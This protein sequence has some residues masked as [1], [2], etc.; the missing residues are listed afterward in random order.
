MYNKLPQCNTCYFKWKSF[1]NHD[2]NRF[3]VL[4]LHCICLSINP[5]WIQSVTVVSVGRFNVGISRR[6]DTWADKQSFPSGV[7]SHVGAQHYGTQSSTNAAGNLLLYWAELS[8]FGWIPFLPGGLYLL[9]MWLLAKGFPYLLDFHHTYRHRWFSYPL[10]LSDLP[11]TD[12]FLKWMVA[13]CI[14]GLCKLWI[15]K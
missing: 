8:W 6:S 13:M 15:I 11:L 10:H 2:S 14:G 1:H 7:A 4:V 3:E 12:I 5:F 9:I